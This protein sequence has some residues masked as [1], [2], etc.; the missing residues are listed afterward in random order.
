MSNTVQQRINIFIL[1]A[2]TFIAAF[3]LF[4]IELIIAKMFLPGYGGSYLVWG[5]CIVFFQAVLLAGYFVAH[6]AISRLGFSRYRWLHLGLLLF[7]LIFFPGRNIVLG[8]NTGQL[9]LVLDVFIRLTATIGPVFLTLST[10]SLVLQKWLSVSDLPQKSNPYSLYAVS[11]VGSF[12]ALI[13]YP[14]V[15]EVLSSIS[16]QLLIWRVL[17]LMLVALNALALWRIKPTFD[18][19]PV[20]AHQ[21]HVERSDIGRWILLSAAGVVLFLSVTTL[22]TSEIA[23]MPLLWIIPLSIYLAA[24]VFNFKSNPWCPKWISERVELLL[25]GS[26]AVYFLVLQNQIPALYNLIILNLILFALCMYCQN[27]LIKNKPAKT[28]N[29]TAF[30]FYLSL[31]GFLGGFITSWVVPLFTTTHCEFLVGLA[32]VGFTLKQSMG[33]EEQRLFNLRLLVY[34]LLIL[35]IWPIYFKSYHLSGVLIL[36]AVLILIYHAF[37]KCRSFI[38]I[39]LSLLVL[40]AGFM[41]PFWKNEVGMVVHSQR[42]YYGA[43]RITDNFGLR[44]FYHGATAHGAQLLD[45]DKRKQPTTYF[46][47]SSPVYKIFH[48]PQF[49]FERVGIVGLGIGIIASYTKDYQ[50]VDFYELD[51]DVYDMAVDYFTFLE[52]SDSKLNYFF[53]DGRRLISQNAD[54]TYDLIIIDAYGGD[55]VPFHLAT[56]EALL[57]YR[58]RLKPNGIVLFHISNRY[59]TLG[60]VISKSA[61]TANARAAYQF[62]EDKGGLEYASQWLVVTWD[63][64]RFATLTQQLGWKQVDVRNLANVRTWTDKYINILNTI[65]VRNLVIPARE[66]NPFRW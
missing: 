51:P 20:A 16:T 29:L 12:A 38:P 64:D 53:G 6:T 48:A 4:Q 9:P 45:P 11:N 15:F 8:E 66:F 41:E 30:Y 18:K 61:E 17:Y 65:K 60:P 7:P 27:Q 37:R 54:I 19:G 1:A 26:V 25:A 13:S 43:Y 34:F 42:N 5:S 39:S 22:M 56:H 3:L 44:L 47:E 57:R 10:I 21:S 62:G 40:G 46:A 24:F 36:L 63:T 33:K 35:I 32:L 55:S 50:T 49:R 31:G 58:E 59:I 28:E 52:D 23:P 14:F 2:I